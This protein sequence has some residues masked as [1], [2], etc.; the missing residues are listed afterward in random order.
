[1]IE[2]NNR[3][4]RS[5]RKRKNQRTGRFIRKSREEIFQVIHQEYES[6]NDLTEALIAFLT[7]K[8]THERSIRATVNYAYWHGC[9]ASD[10]KKC[11]DKLRSNTFL[12]V[13][14]NKITFKC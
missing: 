4:V 13:T 12:D 9:P 11:L 14:T 8:K 6:R 10:F 3:V 2:V 7:P 1:M 5:L